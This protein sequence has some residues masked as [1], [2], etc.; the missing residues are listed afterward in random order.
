MGTWKSRDSNL[1]YQDQCDSPIYSAMGGLLATNQH[2]VF[3]ANLE[4]KVTLISTK[5]WGTE[6]TA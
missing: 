6:I 2:N 1:P 5:A 3:F 4:I